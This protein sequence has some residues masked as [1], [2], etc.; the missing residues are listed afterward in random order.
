MSKESIGHVLHIAR[1]TIVVLL[2]LALLKSFHNSEFLHIQLYAAMFFLR[3][4]PI[5]SQKSICESE[6]NLHVSVKRS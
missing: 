6:H 1:A 3:T 4:Q 5:V 2:L